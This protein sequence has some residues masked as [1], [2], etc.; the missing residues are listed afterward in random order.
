[1]LELGKRLLVVVPEHRRYPAGFF[2]DFAH[3]NPLYLI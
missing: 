3:R 2:D 1:V